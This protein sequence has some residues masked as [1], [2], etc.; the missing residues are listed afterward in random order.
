MNVPGDVFCGELFIRM[1]GNREIIIENHKGIYSYT[2]DEI[3]LSC[4][5]NMLRICGS[6]LQIRYFSGCDMKITGN[7]QSITYV[8]KVELCC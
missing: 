4:K 3:I 5:V 8:S 2:S 7:I 6:N 1:F